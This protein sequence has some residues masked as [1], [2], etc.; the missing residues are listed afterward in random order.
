MLEVRALSKTFRVDRARGT[1]TD[2]RQRAGL[3]HALRPVSFAVPQGS[4]VGVLGPNGAGKTTLLRVL[5][6]AL[7]PS[8][9][10]ALLGGI[11]LVADPREVRRRLGFLS[12]STGVYGRLTAREMVAYFGRLHRVPE[13][14]L[15][16]RI[17]NLFELLHLTDAADRRC[18]ALS[19]GMK[20]K[21]SIARTL[22]HDPEVLVLDEP[23]TGLDVLSAR[24]I[25]ELIARYREQG[26]T[27][28]LATHHMHEVE[29][30]CDRVL[31]LERGEL[32]FEGTVGELRERSG[33]MRLD[34]ALLAVLTY[35]EEASRAA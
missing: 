30:L 24:T 31:V 11:D 5:S 27:V 21:V 14:M 13:R 1:D 32:C 6:T 34:R 3:F 7:R 33:H 22:V 29:E 28:L 2:P 16:R 35:A 26:K 9:G 25:V 20:Q 12:G 10:T 15:G 18:D 17:D 4:I 19:T 8:S 23:T